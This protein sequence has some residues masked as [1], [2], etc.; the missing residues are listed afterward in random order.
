M[1]E[2]VSAFWPVQ[3]T[4]RSR[5]GWSGVSKWQEANVLREI[6]GKSTEGPEHHLENSA[7]YTAWEERPEEGCEQRNEWYFVSKSSSQDHAG[8]CVDRLWETE[9]GAGSAQLGSRGSNARGGAWARLLVLAEAKVLRSGCILGFEGRPKDWLMDLDVG[10][11]ADRRYWWLHSFWS[12]EQKYNCHVR[13]AERLLD[14]VI[15]IKFGFG[16]VNFDDMFMRYS[17]VQIFSRQ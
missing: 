14:E 2:R 5:C 10:C 6:A 17:A 13:R 3:S 15:K 1:K 8:S 11:Q 9:G 4:L 7:A 12:K 16:H